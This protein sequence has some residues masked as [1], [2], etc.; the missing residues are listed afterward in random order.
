MTSNK[1]IIK[2]DTVKIISGAK[3]GVTGRRCR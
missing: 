1:R 3:K 2:G